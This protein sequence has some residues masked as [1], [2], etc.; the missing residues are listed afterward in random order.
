M[1]TN[2]TLSISLEPA[3]GGGIWEELAADATLSEILANCFSTTTG[4][5]CFHWNG[6]EYRLSYRYDLAEISS[7]VVDMLERVIGAPS[8]RCECNVAT[9]C[10]PFIWDVSWSAATVR[11]LARTAFSA[12]D[13]KRLRGIELVELPLSAFLRIWKP[14]LALWDEGI[15]RCGYKNEDSREVVTLRSVLS[16]MDDL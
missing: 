7:A 16:R 12:K 14:V 13:G 10:F 6:L 1:S 4:A 2:Q 15:R 11:V 8:G 9:S 5:A 3:C